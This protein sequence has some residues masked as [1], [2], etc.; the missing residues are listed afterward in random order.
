MKIIHHWKIQK[1]NINKLIIGK[2]YCRNKAHKYKYI[3]FYMLYYI[4]K[5]FYVAI[6][7]NVYLLYLFNRSNIKNDSDK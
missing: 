3:Y 6:I 1:S 5:F 4:N 2:F 7:M